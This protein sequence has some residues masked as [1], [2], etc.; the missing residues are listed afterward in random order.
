MKNGCKDFISP[1]MDKIGIKP[2]FEN[3]L[4]DIMFAQVKLRIL[5]SRG[6][7]LEDTIQ[8][9]QELYK[10]IIYLYSHI[11]Q[12]EKDKKYLLAQ[13]LKRNDCNL[14]NKI[15]SFFE[16]EENWKKL[17]NC[18]LENDRSDDLRKLL[19]KAIREV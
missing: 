6:K 19:H 17:K 10:Y 12:L 11:N 9:T 8:L 5:N 16:K 1:T 15:A 13:N 4:C 18:W 3:R 14:V 2:F 7:C